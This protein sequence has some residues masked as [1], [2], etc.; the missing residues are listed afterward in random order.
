[1]DKD[2]E[3]LFEKAYAYANA[4]MALA[5]KNLSQTEDESAVFVLAM[6]LSNVITRIEEAMDGR[7]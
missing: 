2:T 6:D 4:I 3:L 5:K 7:D 1:M